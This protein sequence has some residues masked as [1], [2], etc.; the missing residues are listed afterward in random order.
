MTEYVTVLCEIQLLGSSK[1]TLDIQEGVSESF[2]REG[3]CL[4]FLDG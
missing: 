3:I 4:K 1:K 2:C